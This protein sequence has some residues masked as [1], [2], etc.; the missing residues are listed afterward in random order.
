M[1]LQEESD[2]ALHRE[3]AQAATRRAAVLEKRLR[4]VEGRER[5]AEG[6]QVRAAKEADEELRWLRRRVQVLE[7]RRVAPP[8]AAA[9]VR[10]SSSRPILRAAGVGELPIL[11]A[12]QMAVRD[13]CTG[14]HKR[15]CGPNRL[16]SGSCHLSRHLSRCRTHTRLVAYGL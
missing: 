1:R 3:A 7:G 15:G 11:R 6:K 10:T 8:A 12:A 4:E 2:V 16:T 13:V 5:Q 9:A 14:W